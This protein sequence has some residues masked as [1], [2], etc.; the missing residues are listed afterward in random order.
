MLSTI[1]I[2]NQNTSLKNGGQT[3][4]KQSVKPLLHLSNLLYPEFY[5][6]QS[7]QDVAFSLCSFFK[8]QTNSMNYHPNKVQYTLIS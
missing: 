7:C 5:F 6:L 4:D 8:W 1:L 3:M 2:F